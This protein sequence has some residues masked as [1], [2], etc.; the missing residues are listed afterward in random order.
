MRVAYPWI[1]TLLLLIPILGL[2]RWRFYR[3]PSILFSTLVPFQEFKSPKAIW[4]MRLAQGLRVL[5]FIAMV[6]AL[7]RPQMVT[8][9]HESNTLGIDIML[10]MDV[11]DSMAA[12]DFQPNNRLAVSKSVMAAF[13][14]QRSGDRM[15]LIAFGDF[16]LTQCPL[17][18]DQSILLRQISAIE[19]SMA[20]GRTAIGMGLASALNRLT[21]STTKSKIVI[22]LTDGVNNAGDIGP[23]KAAEL[24][25]DVGVKV[26]TIGV[27]KEGGAPVPIQHPVLGKTYARNPDGS[28]YMTAI[29]EVALKEM[30]VI[31]GGHYFRAQDATSLANIYTEINQLEKTK[32]KTA[33]QLEIHERFLPILMIGIALLCLEWLILIGIGRV[34]V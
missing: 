31:T 34:R 15:G 4:A 1:L 18:T 22:L 30:A 32:L 10:V 3:T 5:A 7:A 28:L 16:A 8:V 33:Q 21:N 2:L 11:S 13:V 9:R 19:I 29:D 14:K 25:R 23:K 20:G 24:A 17:T 12:E 6:L 26:Y 27:G